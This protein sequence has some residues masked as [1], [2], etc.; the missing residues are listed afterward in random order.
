MEAGFQV[1][2]HAI[3]DLGNRVVL[4]AYIKAIHE[5]ELRSF[6]LLRPN[7]RNSYHFL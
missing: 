7:C 5:L 3:G 2:T 1:C 6:L 4:D